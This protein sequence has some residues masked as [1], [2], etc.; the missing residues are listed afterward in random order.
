M[1]SAVALIAILFAA[2]AGAAPSQESLARI[3]YAAGEQEYA[4]GRWREA[5]REF[6][7]GYDLSPRPEFLLNFAQ[8]Y[9][10]LGD[11]PRAIAECERFLATAPAAPLAAQARH[12]L[13]QLRD[14]QARNRPPPPS[15][16][17]DMATPAPPPDMVAPLPPPPLP[18]PPPPSRPPPSPISV[19]PA[20]STAAVVATAPHRRRWI[21][22]VVVGVVLAAGAAVGIALGVVYGSHDSYPTTPNGTVDFR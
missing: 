8:V 10:K 1:R 2:P 16:P 22:P 4:R 6:Q 15:V 7:I 13:T 20:P 18:P 3:H 5:L 21:A 9:R 17:P 14:E 19:A 11:Y 12:L